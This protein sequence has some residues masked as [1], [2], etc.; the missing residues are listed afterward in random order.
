[1]KY[2]IL[3]L[4]IAL[5]ALGLSIDVV[6]ADFTALV[7]G[8]LLLTQVIKAIPQ[9]KDFLA[10]VVSWGVGVVLTAVGF[11][12]KLGFLVDVAVW[13]FI[14]I[15]IGVSLAANGFYTVVRKILEALGVIKPTVADSI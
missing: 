15:A 12:G 13:E 10:I 11:F 5:S 14:L 1:M 4:G 3:L 6:Y 7:G 9:V 8:T 2:V